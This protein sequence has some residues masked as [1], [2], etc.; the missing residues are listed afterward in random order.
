MILP[1]ESMLL[2]RWSFNS[3][4]NISGDRL[5]EAM[6]QGGVPLARLERHFLPG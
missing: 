6:R 5:S 1:N 4:R 2:S 3:H